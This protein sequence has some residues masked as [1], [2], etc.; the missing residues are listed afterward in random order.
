[1]DRQDKIQLFLRAL[2]PADI[3]FLY[4]VENQEES[5]PVGENR[6]PFSRDFLR[7]FVYASLSENLFSTGQLR[8]LACRKPESD[9]KGFEIPPVGVVD[10][11]N[12]EP[13]HRRAEIGLL[14]CQGLRRQGIGEKILS[15]AC[16]YARNQL[17]LHQLYA[18]VATVNETSL[19]LFEKCGFSSC[20]LRRQWLMQGE[21]WVDVS[22]WQKIFE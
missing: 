17:N 22:L 6:I 16:T 1:M 3:D 21:K 8:L 19:R 15:L 20:G 4:K 7:R 2:E 13:L 11:F 18:E 5:L 9:R 12:Y 10:F 14:V